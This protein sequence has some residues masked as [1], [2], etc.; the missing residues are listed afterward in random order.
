[1]TFKAQA[2]AAAAVGALAGVVVI[3]LRRSRSEVT[4]VFRSS[5]S[6]SSLTDA[7]GP[8]SGHFATKAEL[9]DEA[10]RRGVPGRS[11]MNKAQLQA[12]LGKEISA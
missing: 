5:P 3:A 12:A 2:L 9:Y 4:A 6:R 11:R 10:K 1:M 8:T 7:A